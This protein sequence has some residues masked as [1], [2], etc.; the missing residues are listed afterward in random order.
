MQAQ[1]PEKAT[2]YDPVMHAMRTTIKET[3]IHDT[4][5]NNLKG[6][7]RTVAALTDDA[8][9]TVR[10]TTP[11]QESTRNVASTT[12]RVTVYNVD[13]VAKKTIRQTT[14]E[15]GSQFGFI[16]GDVTEG[17]GAYNYVK[18]EVPN[19]QKQFLSD[20]EYEGIA[21]SKTSFRPMSDEDARNAEIDGTREALNVAAGHV[22]NAGGAYTGVD[23]ANVRVDPRKLVGDSMA[24]RN[25][26]NVTRIVSAEVPAVNACDVTRPA[27]PLPETERLDTRVLGS[28]HSNPYN[29]SINPI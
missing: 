11:V 12:Y 1:I 3:L 18:V 13:A 19:T 5:I 24:A 9:K 29:I 20:Y 21:G 10:E 14:K 4:T 2:T 23:A 28:L 27:V 15:S 8:K 26:G 7:T 17:T 6:A 16:G 22:P 25:V